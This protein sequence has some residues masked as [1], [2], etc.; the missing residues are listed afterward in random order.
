MKM[1]WSPRAAHRLEEIADYIAQDNETAAARFVASLLDAVEKIGVF[2]HAGR[3]VPEY[4]HK[5]VREI[6]YGDY[7][8]IYET[9]VM[10]SRFSPFGTASSD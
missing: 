10:R 2:P 3:R 9:R 7:H 1:I 6:L 4:I 5:R 8:I